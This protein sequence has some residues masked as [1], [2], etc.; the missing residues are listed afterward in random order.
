MLPNAQAARQ[1]TWVPS[2]IADFLTVSPDTGGAAWR[3]QLEVPPAL[4][5]SAQALCAEQGQPPILLYQAAWC[6]VLDCWQADAPLTTPSRRTVRQWLRHVQ[7]ALDR[8]LT[9]RGEDG[10]LA[11]L[12]QPPAADASADGAQPFR[13]GFAG[14]SVPALCLEA[15]PGAMLPE[16]ARALLHTWLQ[17]VAEFVRQPDGALDQVALLASAQR[18]RLFSLGQGPQS[19]YLSGQTVHQLFELVARQHARSVAV[20]QG[21]QRLSYAALNDAADGL[22]ASLRQ[23]GI[24]PGEAVGLALPRGIPCMIALLAL[25][26]AG[27]AYVPLDPSHPPPRLEQML[28]LANA[29]RILCLPEMLALFAPMGQ[30]LTLESLLA[31]D[32]QPIADGRPVSA[33][34]LAYIMFTSGSTGVPKGVEIPHRAIVRL[35][36]DVA[37]MDLSPSV[38]MLHAAPLGF[39]ASTLEIWG[40]LLNGGCCVM[41]DEALPTPAG[42]AQTVAAHS[43][44][45][46][47][48]T[49]ALFNAVVDDDLAHLRGLQQLLIGGEALSVAHVRKALAGL[50]DLSLI[51]GYGPTECTTFAT[52][53][54]IARALPEGLPSIPIGQPIHDTSVWV[55][56]P[57]MQLLPAGLVGELYIGGA[58]LA[59]GYLGAPELSAERFVSHP[60][61]AP[62]E[63]LYR[64]GDLV[65]WRAD[66]TLEFIGRRDGQI[67][68]RG[69]RIE[70]GEVEAVLLRHSAIRACAVLPWA[71]PGG[72]PRL[73]AYVVPALAALSPAVL[74]QHMQRSL[75]AFM[76]PAVYV[77]VPALPLTANGKLDRRALP[78]PSA[79]RPDLPQPY[80]AAQD[81]A[82]RQI[83]QAMAD[84]LGLERVGRDD[85]FFDLGG[86]SLLALRLLP[87]LARALGQPV[88]PTRFFS[89][90]S[91]A[92]LLRSTSGVSAT[93]NVEHQQ[94]SAQVKAGAGR[95]PIAIIGMAGRFPAA[96]DIEQFWAN[97][98]AGHDGITDFSAG[99]LDPSLSRNLTEDPA[100]V[101]SRG[102]LAD[103]D[104]FDAAFFGISP[105]EAQLMDPQQRVFLQLCWHCLERAGQAPDRAAGPVGVFAGMYNASYYQQQLIHRPDLIEQL[106]AFQVMLANEKDYIATRVAHK[107][108]LTGPAIS[109][110]T[111][112]ST[113]LV[114]IAQAVSALRQ[115]QCRMALAGGVSIT[116]PPR[117][118]YRYEQGAMLSPDG[119]TRSFDADAQGTVFSDGAAV[120]LLKPLDLAL[121]DGDTVQAVI[122]GVAVNNDGHD[123]ASFTAPSV[124]G[125]AAVIR[126]ALAD[127]GV[128]ARDIGYV[129]AH[130]TATPLGDPIEIEGLTQAY[131][132]ST[133]DVGFCRI[134]SLKSNVGHMVIAA[135][136]AGVIK[137]SLALARER[138]P[139]SIHFKRANPIIAFAESPFS[140]HDQ[141][142]D[143]PRAQWPRL[144]GVSSFGVGGTNAHVVLQEPPL[145][146]PTSAA[147]G[148]QCLRLSARTAQAL[149]RMADELAQWLQAHPAANLADVA[150]TL[151]VG[152]SALAQRLCVVAG[153]AHQAA[154]ALRDRGSPWRRSAQVAES[155]PG[156]V[157][158]FPGQAAQYP[159]MGLALAAHDPLFAQA[160][161]AAI[162][163]CQASLPFDLRVRLASADSHAL[164]PTEVAQPAIFC[165]EYALAQRWLG[166]GAQP[167]ALLGHSV[168]EFAA[169]VVAGVMSLNDAARLVAR[170]GALMQALPAGG[171]L[172][173]RLSRQAVLNSLPPALSLAAENAPLSCVVSGPLESLGAWQQQQEQQGV[174]CKRLATSH[175]FHS[176]MMDPV[177]QPFEAEVRGLALRP[178]KLPWASTSTGSWITAQEATDP[179]YWVRHLRQSVAFSPALTAVLA[180]PMPLLL[181]LGPRGG[182]SAL[183]RQHGAGAARNITAVSLLGQDRHSEAQQHLLAQ[184]HLW[185][186]G[187]DLPMSVAS[188]ATG[189][190]RIELPVY[191]FEPTRHWVEAPVAGAGSTAHLAIAVAPVAASLSAPAPLPTGV[192]PSAPALID[193]LRGVFED[194]SGLDLSQAD[195]ASLFVELGL[196]S[197]TLTQASIQVRKRFGVAV[198]FRQLLA[199]WRSLRLLADHLQAALSAAQSHRPASAQSAPALAPYANAAPRAEG[200]A[201][202]ALPASDSAAAAQRYDVKKAFGAIARIHTQSH[203]ITPRQRVRLDA[204]IRR[205]LQRTRNSRDYTTAHRGHLA[206]PRVV[207]GFRPLTKEIT[208]QIVIERSQGARLWDIDGNEYVDA[209]CGFGMNLFGW[210]P[211]FVRQA[212]Q[213][214]LDAGYELGPQHPLAGEVAA[215]VCELTGF[216]RAGLCNTGS[217]A[218]MAAVRM[219][220]TVTGRNTVVLFTGSYHGT[221]DEVVVRAGRG[222]K[223]I[224]AAP[225]IMAGMFGDVRVLD[226][227]SDEALAFIRAHAHDLAAVLVEP[228]QSRRPDFQP[229]EFLQQVRT[230]TQAQG[231][232]LIFDEV[233]TGFRAHLGGTQALFDIRADLA[234]YG[235]VIGGGFPIGVVAG[236]RDYMDALDGGAWQYADDSVPSV[237]VTYFAGTFVRHPLALAAAQASLLYLKAQGPALQEQLNQTTAALAAELNAFCRQQGAPLEIRTFASLWRVSWLQDH[238]LQDLLFAMMRSRGVHILDNFPCFLTTAHG[239]AELQLLSQAFRESVLELQESDFLPARPGA[240]GVFDAARPPRPGARLG[241]DMDGQPAWY[242]PHPDDPKRYLKIS[243]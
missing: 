187:L 183:A 23:A 36:R 203:S 142:Q 61:G 117:S 202:L 204:F 43:V 137:A 21:A 12:H 76:Q 72:S 99:Q 233:I 110:H 237:G 83:C 69:Y 133:A 228:V 144:A 115:G 172:S 4:A 20:E 98:V 226:Y 121:A 34:D 181:E 191:S 167:V 68:L 130:G 90:P 175:A 81:D 157:F 124:A 150:H 148:A 230:I 39:D 74:R 3:A 41:H 158:M 173:V 122:R 97:L 146:A 2:A 60:F 218:V 182:L 209:L 221:F 138:L 118:G 46:A 53:H 189:R 200:A 170:R 75:P 114:A 108:N 38:R 11:W 212:V 199:Q 174:A 87:A 227:G 63:R 147:Q 220:R 109:V 192:A 185:A 232:C 210:Q 5:L 240:A 85:N 111:A 152:R 168:G 82:E 89:H 143:W 54:R 77:Q 238:P 134:G 217:E 139:P 193:D 80:A 166:A 129:E 239:A 131:R 176:A 162:A 194:V 35:V 196:D 164:L 17:C 95:M 93:A 214:Q 112:C 101:R 45:A 44:N 73:V 160:L 65:R 126:A 6:W 132:A 216:D 241:R 145:Q 190:R 105:R 55:L 235:K 180:L 215:L 84:A 22:A 161:D 123:K 195:P 1:P 155:R 201:A 16:Q 151:D 184:A 26:K 9:R 58:G 78:P 37:F 100:Y 59:R 219:A 135:G 62:G 207:N 27:A 225:G 86:N 57:G 186:L 127:A 18:Q 197:L 179:L 67:K 154:E 104:L 165:L 205:Y 224:P 163:A 243:G 49:A 64:S 96:T 71:P 31:A 242:V 128:S 32:A 88:A 106:G 188:P 113:S 79:Q 15:R 30:A 149:D 66:G 42:L 120:L 229:R 136:A 208:Y 119:R 25:L 13:L 91:A 94:S 103:V 231:C 33:Q 50:P 52:T 102:V 8:D 206:D 153:D 29:R 92:A 177:L 213:R 107:L 7:E 171:M 116:C 14:T 159:G 24:Q 28:A 169:A 19:A 234:C 70:P 10:A 141:L 140:V 47:W 40:P 223:G 178:P 156:L 51:N 222:G 211:D 56:G 198:T 125:Q 48:L 236:R